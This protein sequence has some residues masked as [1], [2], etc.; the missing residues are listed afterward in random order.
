M[1]LLKAVV[2]ANADKTEFCH[3]VS[4]SNGL[5][6]RALLIDKTKQLQE[7]LNAHFTALVEQEK[8]SNGS[9]TNLLIKFKARGGALLLQILNENTK[10][11]SCTA[12]IWPTILI[13]APYLYTCLRY[14]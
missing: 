11:I 8:A 3:D 14:A 5:C 2:A 12:I 1:A 9:G 7:E 10:I 4:S 13:C 6:D